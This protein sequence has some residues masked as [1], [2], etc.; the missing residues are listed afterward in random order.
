MM[1]GRGGLTLAPWRGVETPPCW[2]LVAARARS[3]S[4]GDLAG[5]ASAAH[6]SAGCDTATVLSS[7]LITA[8]D[9]Q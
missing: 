4:A 8:G 5:L 6:G 1:T 2:L 3:S 9:R 7:A